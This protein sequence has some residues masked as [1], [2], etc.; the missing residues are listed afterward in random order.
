MATTQGNERGSS[1]SIRL[2]PTGIKLG[3]TG[4]SSSYDDGYPPELEGWMAKEE[5]QEC[6]G[7]INRAFMDR[8]PCGLCRLQAYCCCPCTLGLSLL[9]VRK[10]AKEVE[11]G[12]GEVISSVNQNLEARRRSVRFAF[13]RGWCRAWVQ[14]EYG[15]AISVTYSSIASKAPVSSYSAASASTGAISGNNRHKLEGGRYGGSSEQP[16]YESFD[17]RSKATTTVEAM[18]GATQTLGEALLERDSTPAASPSAA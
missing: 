2:E 10:Q 11:R 18:S 4:I 7:R 1:G 13:H 12:V 8:F 16:T 6:M 9:S 14:V 5:W 15:R 17:R 3:A